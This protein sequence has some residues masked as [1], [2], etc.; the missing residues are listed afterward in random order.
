MLTHNRN[1]SP[2][3]LSSQLN[4]S[5]AD[6]TSAACDYNFHNAK[7]LNIE[8]ITNNINS[9]RTEWHITINYN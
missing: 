2:V 5:R 7:S 4:N 3:S 9:K 1:D 6:K 8:Q